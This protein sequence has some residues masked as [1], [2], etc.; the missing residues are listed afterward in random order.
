MVTETFLS[1]TERSQNNARN[2]ISVNIP[3]TFRG[4]S[5]KKEF[6]SCDCLKSGLVIRHD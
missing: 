6:S 3:L 5:E 4:H 2:R 1:L